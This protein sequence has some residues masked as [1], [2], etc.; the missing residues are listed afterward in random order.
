MVP[1]ILSCRNGCNYTQFTFVMQKS[2]GCSSTNYCHL[3]PTYGLAPSWGNGWGG[4]SVDHWVIGNQ[5]LGGRPLITSTN[6]ALISSPARFLPFP[7]SAPQS[8]PVKPPLSRLADSPSSLILPP[9]PGN[10]F[11]LSTSYLQ[12]CKHP[13]THTHTYTLL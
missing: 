13:R 10:S 9:P 1:S 12:L 7:P 3:E 11:R 4:L 2:D 6:L 5:Q 8:P